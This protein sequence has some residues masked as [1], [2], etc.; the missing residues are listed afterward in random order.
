MPAPQLKPL[1]T[2][3]KSNKAYR[4]DAV[5]NIQR[6][7]ISSTNH[8][9]NILVS[10]V[11]PRQQY[12]NIFASGA[13]NSDDQECYQISAGE[14]F[15]FSPGCVIRN[16]QRVWAPGFS[17]IN[18]SVNTSP[19]L[20]RFVT[21]GYFAKDHEDLIPPNIY[22]LGLAAKS[23]FLA[24]E[25]DG[26]PYSVLIPTMEIL[27]FYYSGSSKLN[28][29]IFSSTLT[30]MNDVLNLEK[31][32]FEKN[33][34][35][36]TVCLRQDYP[37]DDAAML[38]HWY[39]DEYAH[40]QVLNVWNALVKF[41]QMQKFNYLPLEIGFPFINNTQLQGQGIE[42]P[43]PFGINK[44]RMLIL[45]LL[46]CSHPRPFDKLIYTRDNEAGPG[47]NDIPGQ[48]RPQTVGYRQ[49][50]TV[51]ANPANLDKGEAEG[52][53]DPFAS[54]SLDIQPEFLK[55]SAQRFPKIEIEKHLKER[56]THNSAPAAPAS[57]DDFPN[58]STSDPSAGAADT[59]RIC[60][61]PTE[62]SNNEPNEDKKPEIESLP[63]TFETFI[64]VIEEL[65]EFPIVT[66]TEDV[67]INPV[68]TK[69]GQWVS[70]FPSDFI[71]HSAIKLSQVFKD[72]ESRPRFAMIVKVEAQCG[73]HYLLEVERTEYKKSDDRTSFD[74][75]FATY[76]FSNKSCGTINDET[77]SSLLRALAESSFK[78]YK[79]I[80]TKIALT[81]NSKKHSGT[82]SN[83]AKLIEASMTAQ[84]NKVQEKLREIESL[85][86]T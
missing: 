81:V 45:T 29:A 39:A 79:K 47:I 69:A 56:S 86:E 44:K 60:I 46:K 57:D 77:L 42:L 7:P 35:T 6:N 19:N 74:H 24:I 25:R 78:G 63:V 16:G 75:E 32:S 15:L 33:S 73:V 8:L 53:N 11:N 36:L 22:K 23:P 76:L 67:L 43:T 17:T 3:P 1:S 50:I 85:T 71:D 9:I 41:T 5:G 80:F 61:V 26:D 34:K 2:L 4:I 66:K 59:F 28:Q 54:P 70:Q 68:N 10:P 52:V 72:G 13:V 58:Q 82:T 65:K 18:E 37:D 55:V 14:L 48:Q 40:K 21:P 12:K 83:R 51:P 27:R 49:R 62:D 30:N 38:G 31:C 64:K 20:I 84:W